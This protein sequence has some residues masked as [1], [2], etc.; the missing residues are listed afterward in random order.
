MS[1]EVQIAGSR[2]VVAATRVVLWAFVGIALLAAAASLVVGIVGLVHT[3]T[4]GLSNLTLV[5]DTK[6]AIVDGADPRY[7]VHIVTSQFPSATVVVSGLPGAIRAAVIVAAVATTL[8]E[9]TLCLTI[10]LLAWRMLRRR[11]FRRSLSL[12]VSLAGLILVIGGL[13]SQGATAIAGSA[14]ALQLNGGGEGRWPIAGRFDPTWIV[15]GI[16]LVLVGLAFEYGE[17]LQRETDGLV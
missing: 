11:P 10:A 7:P 5:N 3:T 12:S 15:F 4:T 17:R 6:A 1:T 14:T 9:V 8:T 16:V 2:P 13:L